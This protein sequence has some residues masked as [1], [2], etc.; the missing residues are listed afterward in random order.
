MNWEIVVRQIFDGR[1][2]DPEHAMAVYRAHT[3]DVKREIPADRLLVYDV[4]EG[5]EPLCR[6]LEVP[7][8]DTPFPHTNTAAEFQQRIKTG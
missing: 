1:L 4:A 7:V 6:F 2:D 3:E 8:P 5:W